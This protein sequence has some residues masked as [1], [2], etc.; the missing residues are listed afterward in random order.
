MGHT[1]ISQVPLAITGMACRLPGADDLDEFWQLLIDGRS[2]I[3]EAPPDRVDLGV[4]YDAKPGVAGRT[5]SKLT[6][7]VSNGE[8]TD[9]RPS[10]TDYLPATVDETHRTMCAVAETACIHAGLD[11]FDITPRNTGVY[12]GHDWASDRWGDAFCRSRLEQTTGL[13]HDLDG[14]EHLAGED[15]KRLVD[16]F[17][18]AMADRLAAAPETA[19]D[20]EAHLVAGLISQSMGLNGPAVA[21]DSACASSLQAMLVAARALQLGSI[22][23]AIVGGAST[24]RAD[25]VLEFSKAGASSATGSRPFDAQ[26][27]GVVCSEGYV[28]IVMKTLERAEADGDSILAVVRGLGCSSDGRSASP[29]APQ[30]EGQSLAIRRAYGT[31]LEMSR[32]QYVEAHAT[33]TQR[34][35]ATELF[36]LTEA[37]KKRLPPGRKIP[38]TSVKA[39]IGHTLEAAGMAGVIKTILSMQHGLIPPAISLTSPNPKVDWDDTPFYVPTTATLWPRPADGGPRR[40]GVDAFGLGGLNMHVVVDEYIPVAHDQ[41]CRSSADGRQRIRI[42]RNEG[43]QALAVIGRGCLLPQADGIGEFEN[44]V[45]TVHDQQSCLLRTPQ[46]FVRDF[47]YDWR[48]HRI[49]PKLIEQANPLDFMLLESV[50]QAMAEAGYD[51]PTFDRSQVGVIVATEFGGDFTCDLQLGWH[52]ALHEHVLSELLYRRGAMP[53]ET[54]RLQTRYARLLVERWP[55]ILDES[56]S[57]QNSAPASRIARTWDLMGGAATMDAGRTAGLTALEVC[58]DL[59]LAGDC[60][61]MVC[62]AGRL[63]T[64]VT[65]FADANTRSAAGSGALLLKLAGQA[66]RDGDRVHG[67][68]DVIP[69]AASRVGDP[70]GALL[71]IGAVLKATLPME[72]VHVAE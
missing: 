29:W 71:G 14:I 45:A 15:R 67:L 38:I 70:L 24:S 22:E 1:P 63:R 65:V 23:M 68:I 34:G 18:A 17:R 59:L 20:P 32:V 49:P 16:E 62:A 28:A 72:S 27:D 3:A 30:S 52:L 5:H 35:D 54:A 46:E 41:A 36:S 10:V 8:P 2:A 42:V 6:G 12:I 7:V 13:L 21:L 4:Y 43:D 69:A 58:R 37:F 51:Q 66:R 56:G 50:D 33:S 55:A 40:A 39:N 48:R 53:E 9:G 31:H 47:C 11:P 19:G 25:T 61:V 60:D 57:F 44:L 26:A 64:D